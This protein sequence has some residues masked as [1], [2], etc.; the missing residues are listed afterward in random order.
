MGLVC[1]QVGKRPEA[2]TVSQSF[3]AI[4]DSFLT[5]L[6]NAHLALEAVEMP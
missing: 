6:D 4:N 2:A 5:V 3:E 1:H